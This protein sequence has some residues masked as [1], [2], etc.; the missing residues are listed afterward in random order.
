MYL[1]FGLFFAVIYCLLPDSSF[2]DSISI[3]G[4]IHFSFTTQA[5]VGYGDIY[6]LSNL[7]R[8]ISWAQGIIG[9][10]LAGLILGI[11][12]VKLL[13]AE[14]TIHFP[15]VLVYD[16]DIDKHSFG[17]RFY[18]EDSDSLRDVAISV[19]IYDTTITDNGRYDT[20]ASKVALDYYM[21]DFIEAGHLMAPRTKNN[22]GTHKEDIGY[23]SD[24]IIIS[25]KNLNK[26]V[27]IRLYLT[28]NF[29]TTGDT[30]YAFKD[31]RFDSIKCGSFSNININKMLKEKWTIK[32][33]MRYIKSKLNSFQETNET[34]CIKCSFFQ[35]CPLEPAALIRKT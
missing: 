34:I 30:Y 13:K 17:F 31:Y 18:H 9:T 7:A 4:T 12:T 5:T 15:T 25:P 8:I 23:S 11:A 35:E 1:F 21:L 3:F 27:F 28:C 6:P 2:N 29:V 16:P 10:A 33:R 19:T 20:A 14:I 24:R 26:N 22:D 32:K